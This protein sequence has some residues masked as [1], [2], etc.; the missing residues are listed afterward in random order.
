MD[1]LNAL[2]AFLV[3]ALIAFAADSASCGDVATRPSGM[4]MPARA[5][6]CFAWYSWSFTGGRT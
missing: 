6:I 5:R 4:G 2:G 3:A 1:E